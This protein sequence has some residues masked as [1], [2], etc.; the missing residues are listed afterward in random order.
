MKKEMATEK[1]ERFVDGAAVRGARHSL[2][3]TQKDLARR[4]KRT[5]N[6]ICRIEVAGEKPGE[7]LARHICAILHM[8]ED[9]F[10]GGKPPFIPRSADEEQFWLSYRKLNPYP[11]YYVYALV[12]AMS[13]GRSMKDAQIF[14]EC[15]AE[16]QMRRRSE[17]GKG[18]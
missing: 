14:A 17:A 3:I 7:S 4:V 13:T 1:V 10:W 9:V 12:Q 2:G 18:V 15:Y 8:T 6:T 11:S 5:T 16:D